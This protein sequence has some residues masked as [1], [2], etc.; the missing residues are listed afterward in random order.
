MYDIGID[1]G[2]TG[3]VA[4]LVDDSCRIIAKKGI[5]TDRSMTAEAMSAVLVS[6]ARELMAESHV[7][8]D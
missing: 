4:G 7:S 1:V 3:I 5:A 2:G 8:P 6:L